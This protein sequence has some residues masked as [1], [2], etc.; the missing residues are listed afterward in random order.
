MG[1]TQ[2]RIIVCP[3]AH[4]PFVDQR[5]WACFLEAAY[6]AGANRLV[7]LG[8]LVDFYRVSRYVKS[9]KRRERF[10]D[11]IEAGN[12]ACDDFDSLGIP[13]HLCFGNHEWRYNDYLEQNAP[14]LVNIA[15]DLPDLFK[16][17][18]RPNC[19]FHDYGDPLY[20]G[21]V[22][23]VHDVGRSGINAARQSL[24][25][26]GGNLV[27]GHTHRLGVVYEGTAKGG[28]RVCMNAGWLGDFESIDYMHKTKARRSWQHGFGLVDVDDRGDGHCQAIPIIDGR[29]MVDGKVVK[30]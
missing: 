9:P 4:H 19:T 26:W 10:D 22:A 25:D 24:A 28:S 5:A 20:V 21:H 12:G 27:F 23:F 13:W 30:A 7:C 18:G 2:E 1:T 16:L 15:P 17:R 14:E 29:C 3:D 6:V 11:E 8:D